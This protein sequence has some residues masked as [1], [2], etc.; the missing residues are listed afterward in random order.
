MEPL[1]LFTLRMDLGSGDLF[2]QL[3]TNLYRELGRGGYT[4]HID[5]VKPRQRYSLLTAR[6]VF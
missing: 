4:V 5:W 6:C 3:Q 2:G 1:A